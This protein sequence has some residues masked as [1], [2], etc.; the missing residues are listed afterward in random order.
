M[1]V[2]K[3]IRREW[4]KWWNCELPWFYNGGD[5]NITCQQGDNKVIQVNHYCHD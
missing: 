3:K 4:F 2:P 1:V 5:K